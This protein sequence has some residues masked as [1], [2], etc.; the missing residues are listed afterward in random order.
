VVR[1][2]SSCRSKKES[3]TELAAKVVS[4]IAR[5]HDA[6]GKHL[7]HGFM[8]DSCNVMRALR[9][10]LVTND[11]VD[12]AYGC[13]THPLSN[14]C[15]DIL[16]LP[17]MKEAMKEALFVSKTI[18]NQGLLNKIYS[19]LCKE[20]LGKIH[21]MILYSASRWSTIN[22]MFCR[23]KHT[24]RPISSLPMVVANEKTERGI[25]ESYELPQ[26]LANVVIRSSFWRNVD[27]SISVFDPICK[28]I[29]VIES[30]SATMSTAYACF[31]FVYMHVTEV[32]T[33]DN[34]RVRIL[35]KVL[36]RWNR[37]YSPVHALA[38]YCDPFF[39]DLRLNVLST[40]G[41][42]AIE[43]GKG[44]LKAQ[45]RAALKLLTRRADSPGS[46]F[47]ELLGEFL[48]FCV[49]EEQFV[50]EIRSIVVYN[51]RLIWAQVSDRYPKLAAALIKVYTAPASFAGVERHHK[52]GKRVHTF[53][54]NRTGAGKVERQVAVLH[55]SAT[56]RRAL[57]TQRHRFEF[58]I[59]KCCRGTDGD[60][61]IALDEFTMAENK[62]KESAEADAESN[63]IDDV[64]A[65]V[66]L[67][68]DM[69]LA[70][71]DRFDFILSSWMPENPA[72]IADLHLFG[73]EEHVDEIDS[74][75]E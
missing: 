44:D 72:D 35:Q 46:N 62:L 7:V 51:P 66:L 28:C 15:E 21:A 49:H 36:Y 54:R 47:D 61:E 42:D 43:L 10:N 75:D 22:Y 30:D 37:I 33:D 18:K 11:H 45:C 39:R 19:I 50:S 53:L 3:E 55:N 56:A 25:D 17:T 31:I 26:A 52:D 8:C 14:I 2:V 29:G 48:D 9:L 23:L 13:G 68:S 4:V 69:E 12:F 71:Q 57:H 59:S 63:V 38:F 20:M 73:S 16:E 40:F 64:D 6:V 32:F 24:K 34:E 58:L 41:R 70:E 5:L 74:N 65:A 60:E 1:G 67:L 27:R